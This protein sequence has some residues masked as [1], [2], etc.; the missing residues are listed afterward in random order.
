M[1]KEDGTFVL[2][3]REPRLD[4]EELKKGNIVHIYPSEKGYEKAL[5]RKEAYELYDKKPSK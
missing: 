4:P 2:D 1:R 5:S 3:D